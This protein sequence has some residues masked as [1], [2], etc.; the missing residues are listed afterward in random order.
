MKLNE[1]L[2]EET[3]PLYK[4]R[5][6]SWTEK[7]RREE[8]EDSLLLYH[9]NFLY[10]FAVADGAGGHKLGKQASE[11]TVKALEEELKCNTEYSINYLYQLIEMKYE[12]INEH[13]YQ[14]GKSLG[15]PIVTTLSMVNILNREMI[16]SNVGDTKVFRIRN[17]K[18]KLLSEVHT[19]AWLQYTNGLITEQQLKDHKQKHVLTKGI[20]GAPKISPYLLNEYAEDRDIYI[21]CSD[22]VY[23]FIS[24]AKM[25]QLFSTDRVYTNLELDEICKKC[26]S[27]AL[28]NKADDNMSI[29]AIQI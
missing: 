16:I 17:N 4:I 7:G 20:G 13:I 11:A 19:V 14:H 12:Q 6:G 22:G 8:N 15:H 28:E 24:E 18:I 27:I 23:N 9:D 10:S 3:K 26:A 25:V 21:I 2:L 1:K 5:Y 29:I